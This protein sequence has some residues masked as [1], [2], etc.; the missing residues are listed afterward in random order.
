[1]IN[2]YVGNLPYET[3]EEEL[4]ALFSTFGQ[5][6]KTA[7]VLDRETGRPRGF[8]FVEM[9]DADAGLKAIEQLAGESFNGRPLTINE[10]RNK[11]NRS[12]SASGSAAVSDGYASDRPS[13]TNTYQR[14]RP[15]P[16]EDGPVGGGYSNKYTGAKHQA[17]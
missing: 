1:M 2:I 8:G 3:T 17:S 14:Q 13:L 10:A 12:E 5:V 6:T 15:T 16:R 11:S 4:V 7:I 9:V